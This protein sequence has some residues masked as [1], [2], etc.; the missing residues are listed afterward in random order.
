M[1]VDT[2]DEKWVVLATNGHPITVHMH[3]IGPRTAMAY[4]WEANPLD[5]DV[6]ARR[7]ELTR[8]HSET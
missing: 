8:D 5:C 2:R 1:N 3:T 6:A 7:G 4:S